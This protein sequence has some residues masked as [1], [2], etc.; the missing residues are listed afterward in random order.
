MYVKGEDNSFGSYRSFEEII[1]IVNSLK[2]ESSRIQWSVQDI[3][4]MIQPLEDLSMFIK[5]LTTHYRLG[6][7]MIRRR[8]V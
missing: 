3:I 5:G 7:L 1:Q 2:Y 8:A 6:Y 4:Q